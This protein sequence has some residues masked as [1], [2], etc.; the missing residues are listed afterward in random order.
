MDRNSFWASGEL[1]GKVFLIGSGKRSM[2]CTLI[3]KI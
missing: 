3:K 1:K 2:S